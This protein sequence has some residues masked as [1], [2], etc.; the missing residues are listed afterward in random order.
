M[1]YTL[2]TKGIEF[3][4]L[5][6]FQIKSHRAELKTRPKWAMPLLILYFVYL[7]NHFILRNN[8]FCQRVIYLA[9]MPLLWH[10]LHGFHRP[11]EF[12][13]LWLRLDKLFVLLHIN[14]TKLVTHKQNSFTIALP[15]LPHKCTKTI[16]HKHTN[17]TN[18]PS[19]V[20][21]PMCTRLFIIQIPFCRAGHKK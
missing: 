18:L 19:S 1:P 11:L 15:L 16:T 21:I 20:L 3:A 13:T 17:K 4:A 6:V 14:T 12:I 5:N 8:K 9:S 7:R 2:A 10:L